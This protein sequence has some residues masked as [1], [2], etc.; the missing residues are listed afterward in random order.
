MARPSLW[1]CEDHIIPIRQPTIVP[2]PGHSFAPLLSKRSASGNA[3]QVGSVGSFDIAWVSVVGSISTT[4]IQNDCGT[5]HSLF[6]VTGVGEPAS[7]ISTEIPR[8]LSTVRR[9][10]SVARRPRIATIITACPIRS[11]TR[12][13]IVE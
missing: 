9:G 4:G 1:H 6:I 13:R 10:M 11:Q 2:K 8:Y 3:R 5:G 7:S 12:R